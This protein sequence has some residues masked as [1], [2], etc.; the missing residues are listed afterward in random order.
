MFV[1]QT[2]L[3]S[4]HHHHD[5]G[6][7]EL[8]SFNTNRN[9]DHLQLLHDNVDVKFS[10]ANTAPNTITTVASM[11]SSP[12]PTAMQTSKSAMS[13]MTSVDTSIPYSMLYEKPKSY[14]QAQT[15]D[16]INYSGSTINHSNNI[17]LTGGPTPNNYGATASSGKLNEQALP[18]PAGAGISSVMDSKSSTFTY[19]A[20]KRQQNVN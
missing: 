2:P 19:N 7:I 14:Q 15:I 17:L 16:T 11:M 13:M 3:S 4:Y 12:I 6:G 8:K 10:I 18:L 9:S 20:N 1:F 5:V